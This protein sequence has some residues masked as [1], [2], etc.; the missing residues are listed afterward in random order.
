M[1]QPYN[2]ALICLGAVT[3]YVSLVSESLLLRYA[4][5]LS[6]VSNLVIGLFLEYKNWKTSPLA[7]KK[8]SLLLL[9]ILVPMTVLFW[10][11]IVIRGVRI[12]S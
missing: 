4:I 3:I 2:T 12:W 8:A 1:K 5:L 10:Y 9:L 11:L 7:V 6:G